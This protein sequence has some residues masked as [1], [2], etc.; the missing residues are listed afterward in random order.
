MSQVFISYAKADA[1]Y[2]RRIAEILTEQGHTVWWDIQIPIG[3]SWA[4]TIEAALNESSCVIVLWSGESRDSRWVKKEARFA[5]NRDILVPALL[6]D[7]EIPFEFED[8]EAAVLKGWDG[9]PS[10]ELENLLARVQDLVGGEEVQQEAIAA[11]PGPATSA[12]PST[13]VPESVL[14]A[15]ATDGPSVKEPPE[16]PETSALEADEG[17]ESSEAVTPVLGADDDL[18]PSEPEVA[19][20]PDAESE[21]SET[22]VTAEAEPSVVA[23]GASSDRADTAVPPVEAREAPATSAPAHT[24]AGPDRRLTYVGVAAG[25]VMVGW[26]GWAAA[27]ALRTSGPEA[28]PEL[29]SRETGQPAQGSPS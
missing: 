15:P 6:D 19:A 11:A 14:E 23:R 1:A 13:G 29:T 16:V 9:G 2:A 10:A 28:Q 17:L 12:A 8:I 21:P 4:E 3:K 22:E 7:S 20:K 24:T 25:I 26:A 18:E 5:F 27:G